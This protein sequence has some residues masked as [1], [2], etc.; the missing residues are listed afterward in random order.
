MNE[1]TTLVEL[2]GDGGWVMWAL[3]VLSLASLAVAL[4]RTWVLR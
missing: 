1:E 3:L 2:M 4:E